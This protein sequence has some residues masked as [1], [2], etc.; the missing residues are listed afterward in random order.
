[1]RIKI[2]PFTLDFQSHR[3]FH[4]GNASTTK[5]L[6]ASR[7][8]EVR[9]LLQRCRCPTTTYYFNLLAACLK[10]LS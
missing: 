9:W 1:M 3:D 8:D 6:D 2:M 10:Q 7:E 5:S 4:I